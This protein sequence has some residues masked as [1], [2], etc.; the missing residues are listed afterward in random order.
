L[1]DGA[2]RQELRPLLDDDEVAATAHRALAVSKAERFPYPAGER[3]Y[4]WP[5]V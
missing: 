5:P 1:S 2:L 4:P 3:P